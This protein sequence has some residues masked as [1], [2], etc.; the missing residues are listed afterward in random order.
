MTDWGLNKVFVTANNYSMIL[1]GISGLMMLLTIVSCSQEAYAQPGAGSSDISECRVI[2]LAELFNLA[3]AHSHRIRSYETG[4]AAARE[5]SRE[6]K[7]SRLPEISLSMSAS[8]L[9]D[10]WVIDRDF[11]EGFKADIPHFG[12]DFAVEASQVLYAGGAISSGIALAELGE[13]MA[14]LDL[15]KNRQEVRFLLTGHYLNLYKLSNQAA[16]LRQ[17]ISLTQKVLNEMHARLEQ[18]VVLKNDI[19]RY[20]L[21]LEN[22]RLRLAQ[23]EDARKILNHQ[24]VSTLQ[25][26]EETIIMPDTTLLATECQVGA[27]TEWQNKARENN[28]GIRQ[29][30]LGVKISRE[31][32]KMVRSALMPRLALVAQ[33]HLN[34]PITIEIPAIDKNFD[35]WFV[36]VGVQYDLSALYKKNRG[37]RK[38]RLDQQRA[39][40]ERAWAEE[41]IDHAVQAAYVNLM[42]SLSELEMQQK[43]VELAQQNY[44]VVSNRYQNDLALLTDMVDAGNMKLSAELAQVNARINLIYGYYKLKYMTHTL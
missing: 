12:N 15:E 26:P 8:I 40:E 43:S 13:Q 23:T 7:R 17:N 28:L 3:D 14:S 9:G 42:T 18:G 30:E 6:V 36:G 21:Q 25:L 16:V 4:V 22:L 27:E 5:A 11:G 1:K 29:A 41:Q 20:E 2:G 19:T 31:E 35:Y 38:A 37:V 32:V 44:E 33:N 24:I 34:G 39:E 10:G